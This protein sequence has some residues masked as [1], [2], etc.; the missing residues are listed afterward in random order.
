VDAESGSGQREEC[1]ELRGVDLAEERHG[2]RPVLSPRRE[3]PAQ[4]DEQAMQTPVCRE[5]EQGTMRA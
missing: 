3:P 4:G 5:Q 1:H 2:R